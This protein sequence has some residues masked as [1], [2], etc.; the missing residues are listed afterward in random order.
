MNAILARCAHR[1]DADFCATDWLA[2]GAIR[3]LH[4]H[5][6]RVPEDVAVVGFDDIPYGRASTPTLTSIS[7]DR[8]EVARAA[9]TS[10]S[11]QQAG[12]HEPR[13]IPVGFELVVRESTAGV[14]GA[15]FVAPDALDEAT[16]PFG[17]ATS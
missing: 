11:A 12:G 1:P 15:A 7:P 13:E 3:S 5:G 4:Q 16:L 10:L 6:L 9:V 17:R 2:L 8:V 14:A